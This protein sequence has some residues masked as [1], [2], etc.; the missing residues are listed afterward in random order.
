MA[1][2]VTTAMLMSNEVPS[3]NPAYL[4]C[5]LPCLAEVIC[6]ILQISWECGLLPILIDACGFRIF[7]AS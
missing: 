4:K 6:P 5:F 3:V 2:I 1:Q 7:D